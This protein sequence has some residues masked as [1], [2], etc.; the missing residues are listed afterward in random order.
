MTAYY[1][2]MLVLQFDIKQEGNYI[3]ILDC[4]VSPPELLGGI[5]QEGTH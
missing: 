2:A 5:K 4:A 1:L 3:T